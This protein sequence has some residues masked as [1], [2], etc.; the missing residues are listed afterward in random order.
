MD[1]ALAVGRIQRLGDLDGD[2]EGL[3]TGNG[4]MVSRSASVSP[5]SN[6]ITRKATPS[7]SP[8]S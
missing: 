5:S 2:A 3:S 6:S 7:C 1:D 8:T 4:A